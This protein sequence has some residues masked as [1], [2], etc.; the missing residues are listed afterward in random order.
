MKILVLGG[1]GQLG[2]DCFHLFKDDHDV[3]ALGKPDLN[4]TNEQLVEETLLS[5][6]PDIVIN[7]AAFT[8]VDACEE[9]REPAWAVNANAPGILAKQTNKLEIPIIHISTDYIFR[10]DKPVPQ[11]YVETDAPLP[12]NYYGL[13]KLEGERAVQLTN[14][15]HIILRTSWIYG[16]RGQNF[17]KT[18]LAIALKNPKQTLR[19]VND[20]FGSLTWSFRL[21]TQI[22]KLM[23]KGGWGIY[24]ASAEAH[25]TWFDVAV[26]FL[27]KMNLPNTIVPCSTEEFPR[28][29]PRPFNSILENQRLKEEGLNVMVNWRDDLSAFIDVYKEQLL[30]ESNAENCQ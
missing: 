10:G 19:V 27:R 1:S 17:L 30:S 3:V 23:E 14:R 8:N 6:S 20:Q 12:I 28:P 16:I 24:N 25:G 11:A 7:C 4:V 9:Q 13:T 29:A 18:I 2:Y 5:H 21:A 15:R 26:F 22:K